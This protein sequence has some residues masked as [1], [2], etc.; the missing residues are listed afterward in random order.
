[1]TAAVDFLQRNSVILFWYP[2][3]F[4]L[5]QMLD[6]FFQ[7]FFL[8][9]CCIYRVDRIGFTGLPDPSSQVGGSQ[10][11]PLRPLLCCGLETLLGGSGITLGLVS[12]LRVTVTYCL[13]VP[14]LK[15]T[16]SYSVF[17]WLAVSWGEINPDTVTPSVANTDAILCVYTDFF[18]ASLQLLVLF[19]DLTSYS[20]VSKWTFHTVSSAICVLVFTSVNPSSCE[21]QCICYI[22]LE[23]LPVLP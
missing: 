1:M 21:I 4:C 15:T 18:L 20:Y 2:K 12:P 9:F 14:C 6:F 7:Y 23:S 3:S 16:L 17:Y 5:E 11:F 10:G 13:D 8:V 22:L 19:S